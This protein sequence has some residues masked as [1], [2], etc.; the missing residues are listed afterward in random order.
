VGLTSARLI[1]ASFTRLIVL[2]SIVLFTFS[3]FFL[4]FLT[5]LSSIGQVLHRIFPFARGLYEDKVANVWCATS[6]LIKWH[7]WFQ[8]ETMVT[9]SLV[10]T[11]VAFL[12][13]C[14]HVFL[15]PSRRSFL[16]ALGVCAWSFYLFSFQVHEKSVLLPLLPLALLISSH[17]LLY[18]LSGVIGVFSMYP[19]LEKDGQAMAYGSIRFFFGL[20]TLAYAKG[21]IDQPMGRVANNLAGKM[22]HYAHAKRHLLLTLAQVSSLV[23]VAMHAVWSLVPIPPRYPD[24]LV[25]GFMCYAAAHFV[26]FYLVLMVNQWAIPE[27]ETEDEM[28]QPVGPREGKK[29]R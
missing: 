4:P 25:M 23:T 5:S 12:P 22:L 24:L 26:V 3:L 11:L 19:L 20:Q 14:L 2:G 8:R 27:D 16:Y 7:L 21:R 15:R 9:A 28:L 6:I 13:S 1:S 17:P 29:V 10:C 18:S